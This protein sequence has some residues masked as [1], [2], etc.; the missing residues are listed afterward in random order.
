MWQGVLETY[1]CLISCR[2]NMPGMKLEDAFK[3]ETGAVDA[4]ERE[5]A[6]LKEQAAAQKVVEDPSYIGGNQNLGSPL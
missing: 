4:L 3:R 5:Y 1:R 2:K 6:W